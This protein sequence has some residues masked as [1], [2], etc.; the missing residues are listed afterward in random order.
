MPTWLL[1]GRGGGGSR[2]GAE[3][4]RVVEEAGV[5]GLLV[6]GSPPAAA[7]SFGSA[8]RAAH[9]VDDE[10]AGEPLAAS[11]AHAG[12]VQAAVEAPR[13]ERGH[14]HA[15]ADLDARLGL[16]GAGDDLLERACAARLGD[17][18]LVA[19]ARRAVGDRWAASRR[20]AGRSAARPRPRARGGRPAARRRAPAARAAAGSGPAGTGRRRRGAS[21]ARRPRGR[22]EP[23]R[24]A[25]EDGHAVPVPSQHHRGGQP[26]EAA[27]E[28]DRVGHLPRHDVIRG[29]VIP[30]GPPTWVSATCRRRT[31]TRRPCPRGRRWRALAR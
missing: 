8:E 5:L 15:A 24:V 12:D 11:V 1:I 4:A 30:R 10:V 14:A 26:A 23:G 19:G 25:L 28:H 13:L 18:A 16:G 22:R 3:E 17:E 2:R 31:G 20:R 27:A 7:S 9:R 6:H 29:R 21:A